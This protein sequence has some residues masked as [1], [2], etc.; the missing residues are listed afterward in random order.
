MASPEPTA[1]AAWV[2]TTSAAS[3]TLI[4][5]PSS[6]AT[7]CSRTSRAA[8]PSACSRAPPLR[9][10]EH[11]PVDGLRGLRREAEHEPPLVLVEQPRL[12][13]AEAQRT[14]PALADAPAAP[15]TARRC[16]APCRSAPGSARRVPAATPPTPAARCAAPRPRAAR[17]PGVRCAAGAAA[18]PRSRPTTAPAGG[19][20]RPGAAGRRR[21]RRAS[22][23][24]SRTTTSATSSTVVAP[25][26][27]AV[28][29]CRPAM[30]SRL[31]LAV[32]SSPSSAS[33]RCSK[34]SSARQRRTRARGP[35][36]RHQGADVPAAEGAVLG[37]RLEREQPGGAR[38]GV[39]LV[40]PG[41]VGLGVVGGG[42]RQRQREV[43]SAASPRA[44]AASACRLMDS[45]AS[46]KRCTTVSMSSASCRGTRGA[47]AGA[48]AA[49]RRGRTRGRRC[50]RAPWPRAAARSGTS[51]S[52]TTKCSSAGSSSAQAASR[53]SMSPSRSVSGPARTPSGR[54]DLGPDRLALRR[55]LD[56]PPQRQCIDQ[57]EPATGHRR[58]VGA[59]AHRRGPAAV[60]HLDPH[61]VVVRDD[62]KADRRRG[63]QQRVGHEFGD[64][65]L[66]IVDEPGQVGELSRRGRRTAV[67]AARRRDCCPDAARRSSPTGRASP[68]REIAPRRTP[69]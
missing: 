35:E 52:R 3:S 61:P 21:G 6:A 37:R 13:E 55:R 1:S 15:R 23:T 65:E 69:P 54:T 59:A 36:L 10:V 25:A 64:G 47:G 57:R 19:R 42:R 39:G 58:D 12:L 16:P 68:P 56:A 29:V 45:R 67:P 60:G 4:A 30:R 46:A 18:G 11:R 50:R 17:R 62:A 32:A 40:E 34:V 63:V 43:R 7:C 24:P 49:T 2:T 33:S 9:L 20:P 53:A 48:R 51:P 8:R 5:R 31:A 14:E 44:A 28:T 26:R 38:V 41:Q 22:A 27:A 66:R